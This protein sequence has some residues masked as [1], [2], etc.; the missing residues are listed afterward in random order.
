MITV[1]SD[2]SKNGTH[3]VRG[4]DRVTSRVTACRV[5]CIK[6]AV[7][8][9]PRTIETNQQ[10]PPTLQLAGQRSCERP[11]TRTRSLRDDVREQGCRTGKLEM[12]G[13]NAE[14]RVVLGF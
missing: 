5:E 4:D 1:T 6:R 13:D 2:S 12:V 9:D 3:V 10:L 7:P 14:G 8:I 11:M